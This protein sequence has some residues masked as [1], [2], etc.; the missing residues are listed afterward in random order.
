MNPEI[1]APLAYSVRQACTSA[2]IG[3]TKLYAAMAAGELPFI[4]IGRR[5]V[6]RREALEAW[7]RQRERTAKV[8]GGNASTA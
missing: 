7:L 3:R 1:S 6:V 8:G 5:R 2:A 4:C